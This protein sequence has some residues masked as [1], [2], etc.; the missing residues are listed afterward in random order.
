MIL[1][2]SLCDVG[3]TCLADESTYG[4]D[5]HEIDRY[6]GFLLRVPPNPHSF[7]ESSNVSITSK[8]P[9]GCEAHDMQVN[10]TV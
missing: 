6:I 8:G 4:I 7:R 9:S 2:L 3:V 5:K 10:D 1:I